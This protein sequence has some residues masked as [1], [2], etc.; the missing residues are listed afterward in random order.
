MGQLAVTEAEVKAVHVPVTIIVGD[1]DPCRRLYAEPL[2]RTCLDRPVSVIAD[3][4]HLNCILKPN[5]QA[6]R[7]VVIDQQAGGKP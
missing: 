6:Q 4:G 1:H 7:E 3:A 2:Q 5:F